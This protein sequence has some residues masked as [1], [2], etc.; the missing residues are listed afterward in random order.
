[1]DSTDWLCWQLLDSAFPAGGFSHSGGLEAAWRQGLLTAGAVGEGGKDAPDASA[2]LATYLGVSL[3]QAAV[4]WVPLALAVRHEPEIRL[5]VNDRLC[6]AFLSNHVARQASRQQGR[7]FLRAAREAFG[8][9]LADEGTGPVLDHLD[10][11]IRSGQAL[12]HYAPVFGGVCAALGIAERRC[13]ELVLFLELRTQLSAAVRL[14]ITGPMAAQRL[15]AGLGDTIGQ[16]V[17]TGL[18]TPSEQICQLTPMLELAQMNQD[19]LY[20]RLFQS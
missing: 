4:S 20:T 11:Q 18:A 19:R 6:E 7:S 1:M 10:G 17:E 8:T 2:V 13:A 5:S 15:Q 3:K 9:D 14:G 16:C 12:G